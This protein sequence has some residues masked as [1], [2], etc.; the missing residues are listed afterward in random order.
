MVEAREIPICLLVQNR[1]LRR[2]EFGSILAPALYF[3]ASLL[4]LVPHMAGTRSHRPARTHAS[5]VALTSSA[6]L[7]IRN[8]ASR[9]TKT[10]LSAMT[11]A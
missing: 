1:R 9:R 7:R 8:A 3:V 11:A 6:T 10:L 2:T 4:T 5:V